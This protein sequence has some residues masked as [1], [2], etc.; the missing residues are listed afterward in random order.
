MIRLPHLK[1]FRV[2]EDG[3]TSALLL[4]AIHVPITARLNTRVEYDEQ[5]YELTSVA[6]SLRGHLRRHSDTPNSQYWTAMIKTD[7]D[8]GTSF[9]AWFSSIGEDQ[10]LDP[11]SS[12]EDVLGPPD[13]ELWLY[14]EQSMAALW[15]HLPL[16]HVPNLFVMNSV[17]TRRIPEIPWAESFSHARA[18]RVLHVA[19]EAKL[20]FARAL[21]MMNSSTVLDSV[22]AKAP[23]RHSVALFPELHSVYLSECRFC[24][25]A[26]SGLDVDDAFVSVFTSACQERLEVG[27]GLEYL[28]LR[29]C[30]RATEEDVKK[31]GKYIDDV[32]WDDARCE[33]PELW[34]SDWG[35]EGED[36]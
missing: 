15:R 21:G 9:L 32:S 25:S 10:T 26:D 30:W 4:S 22:N 29:S 19:Y 6:L 11:S 14:N 1:V 13:I 2:H 27:A 23:N 16:E 34:D 17:H 36:N 33:T 20:S 12:P 7:P 28:G 8:E 18:V 3:V 31:L 5:A 24:L 35:E